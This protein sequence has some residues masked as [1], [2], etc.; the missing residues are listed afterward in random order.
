M[1]VAQLAERVTRSYRASKQAAGF[2]VWELFASFVSFG[3][4]V[5]LVVVAAL[6]LVGV[7]WWLV[8]AALSLVRWWAGA[9]RSRASTFT[10]RPVRPET[11]HVR[12]A[13]RH[14]LRELATAR[15]RGELTWLLVHGTVGLI[16]GV[17][18]PS[19][20][21]QALTCL[22]SVGYWWALP[23]DDP[24]NPIYPVTSWLL[25]AS[26][27]PIAVVL[28]ALT[29]W[30]APWFARWRVAW[31]SLLSPPEATLLLARVDALTQS[32]AS[33]LE[34]HALEL[35]R[36]E[37]DL[38]DGAQNRLVGVIMHLGI[39]E[40]ALA[41]DP[42]TATAVLRHAQRVAEEALFELRH[43]VRDIYPPVLSEHGLGGAVASIAARTAPPVT[44]RT[45]GLRRA[46]AAVE[47]AAYFSIAEA[48]TNVQRHSGATCVD[49]L[50]TS[51]EHALVVEVRDDGRGGADE[52]A[53]SGLA[54]IRRRVHAFEGQLD[55]VSPVGGPTTVR[56]EL[57]CA[58]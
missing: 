26:M 19:L 28:F 27:V 34:A 46:P 55:V 11:L 40:R 33:A 1:T 45:N 24:A 6:M 38:H 17:L 12:W 35:R 20:L 36:I 9:E 50:A 43:T 5:A 39:A 21:I 18:L 22:L 51:T 3:L 31:V 14:R 56:I 57:P 23:T 52:Q 32:R 48:L 44:V 8:P 29:V 54:G 47:A 16:T 15:T 42:A 30:L 53:G 49:V 2:L 41:R 25:A 4:L 37:R 7:G 10:G 58:F 13:V